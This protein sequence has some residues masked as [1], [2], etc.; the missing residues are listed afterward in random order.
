MVA[1]DFVYQWQISNA[2]VTL[3]WIGLFVAAFTIT[4]LLCR[5][6]Q[7]FIFSAAFRSLESDPGD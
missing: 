7:L 5:F 2:D 3:L 4:R 1:G 6:M